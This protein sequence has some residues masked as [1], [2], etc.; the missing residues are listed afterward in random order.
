VTATNPPASNQQ[1][2]VLRLERA[3]HQSQPAQTCLP[4]GKRAGIW[5]FRPSSRRPRIGV[6]GV[7]TVGGTVRA[8]FQDQGNHVLCYDKFNPMRSEGDINDADIVFV[9]VPTP[10]HRGAG[11]DL[12]GVFESVALLRGR[13]IVVVKSTCLPGTTDAL[14]ARYPQHTLFFNPE[15]LREST[16][17]QDF[18]QPDRQLM[19]YC[20]DNAALAQELLALLPPAPYSRALPAAAAES[21]KMLTNAFL[22]LKVSFANEVYDLASLAGIDYE[23]VRQGLAADPRIG[24]SHMKVLDGGYRG[25]GGKCLPKDLAGIIDFAT[26]MGSPLTIMDAVQQ[27]NDRLIHAQAAGTVMVGQ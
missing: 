24:G 23:E 2:R 26:E 17:V 19:G 12:D 10:Y 1:R 22:A 18:L 6:I 16:P 5:E 15:F 9:C 14:Q 3:R 21:I 11:F 4:D 8:Y 27:V 13:K 7:G 20:G 25:F